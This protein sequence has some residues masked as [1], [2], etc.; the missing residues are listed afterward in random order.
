[1]RHKVILLRADALSWQHTEKRY[2]C[3]V[4]AQPQRWLPWLPT[5]LA[6]RLAVRWIAAGKGCDAELKTG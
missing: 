4:L 2:V 3:A 6:R 1:M 5:V